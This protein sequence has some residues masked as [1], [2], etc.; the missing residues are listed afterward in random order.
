MLPVFIVIPCEESN[1]LIC[2]MSRSALQRVGYV[3]DS[4]IRVQE[5]TK[6]IEEENK[7][8]VKYKIFLLLNVHNCGQRIKDLPHWPV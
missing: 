5:K 1:S 8:F 3:K 2:N 6:R 7:V 4:Q